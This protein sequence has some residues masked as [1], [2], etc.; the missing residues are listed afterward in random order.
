MNG[1]RYKFMKVI[2]NKIYFS[3]VEIQRQLSLRPYKKGEGPV[4]IMLGTMIKYEYGLSAL[5]ASLVH[6]ILLSLHFK[7]SFIIPIVLYVALVYII[8]KYFSPKIWDG[9]DEE[10]FKEFR[11]KDI[12]IPLWALIG[13][14]F[15]LLSALFNFGGLLLLLFTYIRSEQFMF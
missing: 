3:F 15:V 1:S 5:I 12:D 9:P 2:M 11:E 7:Y 10:L 4:G 14:M 6:I 13:L 8:D